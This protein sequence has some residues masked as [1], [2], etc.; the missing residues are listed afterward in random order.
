MDDITSLQNSRVKEAAKLRER[1]E[2]RRQ[3]RFLIDGAREILRALAGG[4]ELVEVFVCD[5]LCHGDD[6]Q[7]LVARLATLPVRQVRVP[8]AV[9]AKMAFGD[10]AEGV[11]AVAQTPERTLNDLAATL[12]PNALVVV[13]EGIEKPGNIGAVLRQRRCDGRVGADRGRRRHRSLQSEF[14]TSESRHDFYGSGLRGSDP[15]GARL[16]DRA[17]NDR[18][19][20]SGRR[21]RAVHRREFSRRLR[22][23]VGER[24]RR[25]FPS[26]AGSQR[27]A[28]RLADARRGRQPQCLRGRRRVVL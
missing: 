21:G 8:P 25:H 11:L 20:R 1:R 5:A 7:A 10:R 27:P 12:P 15:G 16:A 17:R 14:D 18:L 26:L 28:N 13:L 24:E 3:G 23:R 9:F 22:N 4:I 2:R 19:C 6:C